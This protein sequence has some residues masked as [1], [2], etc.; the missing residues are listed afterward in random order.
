MSAEVDTNVFHDHLDICER[1][2]TKPFDLCKE[3]AALL[4]Q[5]AV[6]KKNSWANERPANP[7]DFCQHSQTNWTCPICSPERRR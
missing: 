6:P 3:G 4:A 2:R 7:R 5:A 1:C